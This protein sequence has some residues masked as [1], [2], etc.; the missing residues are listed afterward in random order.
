[1]RQREDFLRTLISDLAAERPNWI[2]SDHRKI[3]WNGQ[4]RN[5][6]PEADILI[7][8]GSH[9]FI[10]EYDEDSDPGRSLIKY[11]PILHQKEYFLT[12]IEVWKKG[13]TIG[14]GY[15]VLAKWMGTR[16]EETYPMF[17]YKFLER[18][19]ETSRSIAKTITEAIDAST[20]IR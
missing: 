19:E 16:L 3:D 12:I 17:E 5:V 1:M 6:W 2:V 18:N 11:W 9:L 10:I 8:M 7:D 13:R 14:T 4:L 15:A 20:L